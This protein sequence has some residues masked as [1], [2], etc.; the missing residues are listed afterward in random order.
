MPFLLY[1]ITIKEKPDHP[2]SLEAEISE[3]KPKRTF[4][5]FLHE[6][7]LLFSNGKF[8]IYVFIFALGRN[9]IYFFLFTFVKKLY[10]TAIL[11]LPF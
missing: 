3:S 8:V 7:F 6:L 4:R 11:C 5:T 10:R 1:F 9:I 2:P